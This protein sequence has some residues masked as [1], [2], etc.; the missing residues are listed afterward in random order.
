MRYHRSGV[1]RLHHPLIGDLTLDFEALDL[2][3]DEGQ[4]LNIYTAA[5]HTRAAEALTLLA[6]WTLPQPISYETNTD[7]KT[8]DTAGQETVTSPT[9]RTTRPTTG[10]S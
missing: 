6:S 9:P 7:D 10:G 1:K 3:G 5:P 4:R 8:A 2:P